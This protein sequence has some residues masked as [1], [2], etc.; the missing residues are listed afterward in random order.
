ENVS[1][2][3]LV[4]GLVT[5]VFVQQWAT[6]KTGDPLFQLDDRDLHAELSVREAAARAQAERVA[7]LKAMPRPED[8]PPL[9]ANV[10]QAE[11]RLQDNFAQLARMEGVGDLAA[12]SQD[13]LKRKRFDVEVARRQ[14][15][16][17]QADL[18]QL[19]AGAWQYDIQQAEADHQLAL[20]QAEQARI[21]RSRLLVRASRDGTV[22]QV[23]I[24]PGEYVSTTPAVPPILL[25]DTN[26]FR[27]ASTSMKSMPPAS[28]V[29]SPRWRLSRGMPRR[30]SH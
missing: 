10:R 22:L 11:S 23:N 2:A 27:R 7:R 26:R 29:G 12:V 25:G 14:L 15:E 16:K 1:I 3:P 4:P 18:K 21:N 6:V 19:Q 20:S 13:E 5:K 9:E 8:L 30:P 24:R 28:P 17:A